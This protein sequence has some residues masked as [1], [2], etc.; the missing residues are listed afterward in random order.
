M[1]RARL[2]WQDVQAAMRP[3]VRRCPG[4]LMLAAPPGPGREA[5]IGV[6]HA[7]GG[8]P[9]RVSPPTLR[10]IDIPGG[11]FMSHER[12]TGIRLA[13]Q[14]GGPPPLQRWLTER[15]AEPRADQDHG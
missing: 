14:R 3:L 4:T 6:R 15:D 10:P 8:H 5:S 7:A 13:Q 11:L 9:L 2:T 12:W 1:A